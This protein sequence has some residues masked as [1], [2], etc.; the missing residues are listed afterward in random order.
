MKGP[1][2]DWVFA[3]GS[4]MWH[5]GFPHEE[6]RPAL[7][8]GYHRAFCINSHHYRGTPERPGL[9]LG[10]DRGGSCRGIA[11][12]VASGDRQAVKDYLDERELVSY[13]YRPKVFSVATPQGCVSAY[14]YVADRS[15][16]Q[17]AGHLGLDR[18]AEII[19]EAEG[20]AGLNRDYLI[21][22]VR[23]LEK[24]GFRDE[25]LHALLKRVEHLTGIIEA[26][27]GI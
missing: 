12:R 16:H 7:L 26:G 15:H 5:P 13:A 14:A 27:G 23:R 24:E 6:S 1:D 4:L 8:R 9:V 17:Y 21:N 10:L 18:A 20:C 19:M 2:F 3:Y 22:T 25:R 11:F